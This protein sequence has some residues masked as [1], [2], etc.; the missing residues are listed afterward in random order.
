MD[1][2]SPE[3]QLLHTLQKCFGTVPDLPNHVASRFL[4]RLL[5][6]WSVDMVVWDLAYGG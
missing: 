2:L 3:H 5:A 6:R 4:S 1:T